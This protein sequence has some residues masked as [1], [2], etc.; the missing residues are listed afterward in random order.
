MISVLPASG[1]DISRKLLDQT[2]QPGKVS[3]EPLVVFFRQKD[4]MIFAKGQMSIYT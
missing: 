2:V 3:F 1:L 4:I